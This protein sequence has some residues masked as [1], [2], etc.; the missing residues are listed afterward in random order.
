[1]ALTFDFPN[2]RGFLGFDGFVH[3]LD[4]QQ[5]GSALIH[6]DLPSNPDGAVQPSPCRRIKG[7]RINTSQIGQMAAVDSPKIKAS[8]IEIDRA[9]SAG[10]LH[11]LV[12]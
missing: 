8:Q 6:F 4:L 5:A 2:P 1:M 11:H 3:A 10:Q 9:D 12:A 7:G